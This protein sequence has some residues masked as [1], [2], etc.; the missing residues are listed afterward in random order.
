MYIGR[1]RVKWKCRW[2]LHNWVAETALVSMQRIMLVPSELGWQKPSKF[3]K[4]VV[5]TGGER[6]SKA[7]KIACEAKYWL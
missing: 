1:C 6:Y 5:M 3:E 4:E 7:V 2:K